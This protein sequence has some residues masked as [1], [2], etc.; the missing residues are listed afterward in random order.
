MLEKI[1]SEVRQ[2]RHDIDDLQVDSESVLDTDIV[3][4]DD[5]FFGGEEIVGRIDSE[6]NVYMGKGSW[7]S[8]NMI[9]RIKRKNKGC[10]LSTACCTFMNLPDDC[11]DLNLLRRFRDEFLVATQVGRLLIDRYYRLAPL[12]LSEIERRPDREVI[13]HGIY[14]SLVAPSVK[15]IR[16]GHYDEAICHYTNY[17]VNLGKLVLGRKRAGVGQ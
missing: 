11:P 1:L 3:S 6:G 13:L 9:G 16:S 5:S 2:V 12:I 7:L 4:G 17:T 15:K 14:T 10:F 8:G